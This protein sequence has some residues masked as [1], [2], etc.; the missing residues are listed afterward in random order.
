MNEFE[1]VKANVNAKEAAGRYG[2][3]VNRHG[4]LEKLQTYLE[5]V[6]KED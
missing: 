2:V 1:S 5:K 4:N 6:E 3:E